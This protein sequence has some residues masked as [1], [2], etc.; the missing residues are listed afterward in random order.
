[1]T[2]DDRLEQALD[3]LP[4]GS[5]AYAVPDTMKTGETA[6]V[7]ARIGSDKVTTSALTAGMKSGAASTLDTVATPVAVRMKV[8]LK[9]EDFDI[10]PLS[11]EEQS[12]G[13]STPTQWDWDVSPRHAGK[14]H[15]RI[16][17][18]VVLKNLSRDFTTVDRDIAVTVDPVNAVESFVSK[19]WQWLAGVLATGI[20]AAWKFLR[21]K[22]K[23]TT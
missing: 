21:S 11:S 17:A 7:T 1:M 8:S 22:E 19:N 6:R 18:T 15:L 2:D 13:G 4:K 23:K 12:V 10:S 9:S 16:A 20:A 3:S 14:L 5:M